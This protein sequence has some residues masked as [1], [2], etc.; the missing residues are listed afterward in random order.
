MNRSLIVLVFGALLFTACKKET[1]NRV[2]KADAGPAQ[3]ITLP[4]NT[5]TLT[6][7]GTDDDGDVVAYL[8]SQVSGP[9]AT[10]ITNP[11]SPNTAVTG[12]QQGTYI[13]QLMVTDDMGA[14]GVDTMKVTVNQAQIKTLTLQ[15][16]K[17]PWEYRAV[18]YNGADASSALDYDIPV[19]AW[20]INGQ[21]IIERDLI[22]FDLSAI[23]SNS[24]IIS[25]N[26]YLYSHP[27][28]LTNGNFVDANFGTNNTMYVQQIT[29]N[30]APGNINWFN[31]PTT[32]T[33]GQVVV[34]HTAQSFLDLNLDVKSM[35]SS[36]VAN[37]ANYGFMMKLQNE[38]IYTCRIF[39][40]SQTPNNAL[41]P[42]IPKLVIVY[43]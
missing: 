7:T 30:W 8:W 3:A 24:T 12:L 17:N 9:A 5:V 34:P 27:A 21:T 25:A 4:T 15:P 18:I 32:T 41:L 29:S 1:P 28:P 16:L 33:T 20:T 11:G 36:Q 35:V 31:Q 10:V 43:Q 2:P 22:K 37:N 23:P 19:I 40:S 26:L 6:G 13:F 42:K 38:Q 39:V 14:T